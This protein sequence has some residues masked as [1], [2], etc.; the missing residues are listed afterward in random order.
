MVVDFV[1]DMIGNTVLEFIDLALTAVV[2]MIFW[3]AIKFFLVAPPTEADKAASKSKDQEKYDKLREWLGTKK[4]KREKKKGF[5]KRKSSLSGILGLILRAEQAADKLHNHELEEKTV[6]AVREAKR[7]ARE[8]ETN[9]KHSAREIKIVRNHQKADKRE[10]FQKLY[11]TNGMALVIY[12]DHLKNKI[13]LHTDNDRVWDTKVIAIKHYADEVSKI[14][15]Y[16]HQL[17]TR[18]IDEDEL[19]V[20]VPGAPG[21]P[22]RQPREEPGEIPPGERVEEE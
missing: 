21:A 5:E 9:L 2:I 15:A 20:A 17:I 10:A 11:E 1:S 22:G 7:V 6:V 14:C 4:E 3:Y 18:F 12:Q 8:I 13:P 19:E 16:I